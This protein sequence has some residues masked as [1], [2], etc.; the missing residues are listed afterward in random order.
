MKNSIFDKFNSL[1]GCKF[2]GFNGYVS[3]TGEKSN[4]TVNVGISEHNMK[5]SDLIKLKALTE[6]DLQ[7][8][9]TA[10]NIAL[11]IVKL[12]FNELVIA[13]E[14]NLSE[15]PEDR[16]NQSQAQTDAYIHV[17][18]GIKLNKETRQLYV[19]GLEIAKTIIELGEPKK[20]VNSAPKTIAKKAIQYKADL[21][22]LKY[23]NYIFENIDTLKIKGET[24]EI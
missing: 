12:G 20:P 2:L 5:Q 23:R 13:A 21:S 9:A 1:N 14:K 3:K 19:S 16:S 24:I 10:K 11:D 4:F 6:N 8:V 18:K 15:N 22:C 7:A 17:A